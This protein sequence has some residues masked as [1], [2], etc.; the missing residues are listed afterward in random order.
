MQEENRKKDLGIFYT[1]EKIIDFIF[2]ILLFWKEKE[3]EESHRWH[4]SSGKKKYPSVIDPACGDGGFLKIAL[5]K[6]FTRPDYIWGVDID[7][8]VK[9]KWE[10]I[11]LLKSFGSKAELE[12]HFIHQNGLLPLPDKKFPRKKGGLREFDCVVGN[13]PYGGIGINPNTPDLAT[14]HLLNTL[15][16]Y[17]IFSYKKNNNNEDANK[18]TLFELIPEKTKIH[19]LEI[20]KITQGMPIEILFVE[21]FIQLTKPGG[22]IAMII[23]D[24]ILANA[25]L[26]YVRKFIAAKTKIEGIVSLPREAF[27]NVGTSAKTSIL[28]LGKPKNKEEIENLDYP[29]FLADVPALD[30]LKKVFNY[31]KEVYPMNPKPNVVKENVVTVP[32]YGGATVMVRVDKSMRDFIEEKPSSRLDPHHWD[33]KFDYLSPLLKRWKSMTLEEL[34]GRDCVISGDHVRPSKGEKKEYK[35]GTGIEY[36]ETKN[37]LFTGYNYSEIKECSKNAYERLQYTSVKQYDIL[38]SCAGVG[39]VGKSR[40]CIITHNPKIKSCTGD[41]FIIRIKHL[42]PFFIYIFLNSQIGKDQIMR[43]KSGVGTE[44]INTDETLALKIPILPKIVQAHIETEYKKIS[45]CHNNAMD[46]KSKKDEIEYRKNIEIA[47]KM[48][49]DLI[50]RT[51]VV[52]HGKKEDII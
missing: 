28:F 39:G 2:D 32:F 31:Y 1:D 48:L 47:E 49:K 25:N 26:D 37:F 34:E 22:Y 5:T 27:K 13:P 3:D 44:N 40:S 51:E 35:L 52:I 10:D 41:V 17:E 30:E 46:A 19:A 21:R 11:T 42:T 20:A 29:V 9:K 45:A 7:E 33:V 14:R 6:H 24:G 50:V 12:N 16:E 36:Y 18:K 8:E 38:I 4:F 15:K 23:P 43:N